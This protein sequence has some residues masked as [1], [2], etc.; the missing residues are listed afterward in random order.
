MTGIIFYCSL[1]A[2][3]TDV[4]SLQVIPVEKLV[5]GRF[6]DNFEFVQWFKKFFDANYV[7]GQEYDAVVA[8]GYESLG[9]GAAASSAGPVKKPSPSGGN[10]RPAMKAPASIAGTRNALANKPGMFFYYYYY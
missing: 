8:R 2:A 7:P 5:K 6:Q 9:G 10:V 1:N 3:V 4:H